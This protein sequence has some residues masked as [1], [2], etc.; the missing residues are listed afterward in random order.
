MSLQLLNMLR[1]L[2]R[3]AGRPFP[4]TIGLRLALHGPLPLLATATGCVDISALFNNWLLN[5]PPFTALSDRYAALL[6]LVGSERLI[7]LPFLTVT[8]PTLLF[9]VALTSPA[10][11]TTSVEARASRLSS[12]LLLAISLPI[13]DAVGLILAG[14]TLAI[15]AWL[16]FPRLAFT[17]GLIEIDPTDEEWR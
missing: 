17:L 5:V 7:T 10:E 8:I 2:F 13:G 1:R 6:G 4:S 3:F 9:V 12:S 15:L 14:A 11:L 16:F